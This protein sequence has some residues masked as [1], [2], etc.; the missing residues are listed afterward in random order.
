M[1]VATIH[2]IAG[3]LLRIRFDGWPE[4]YDQWVDCESPDIYPIGWC[5][6]V[7]HTL[8][9]PPGSA[10]ANGLKDNNIAGKGKG[11]RKKRSAMKRRKSSV[12]QNSTFQ[13][14]KSGK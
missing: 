10:A 11:N 8:E 1:C 5:E 4:G 3:R 14:D 2:K 7:G 12:E 6:M 9:V 13:N